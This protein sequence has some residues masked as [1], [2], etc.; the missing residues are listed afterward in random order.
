MKATPPPPSQP[1]GEAGPSQNNHAITANGDRSHMDIDTIVIDT[2]RWSRC[3][4]PL[5]QKLMLSIG[6][7]LLSEHVEVLHP[8][9]TQKKTT[10]LT[11]KLYP[12]VIVTTLLLVRTGY[13]R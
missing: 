1:D 5:P 8:S 3:K 6:I 13:R 7:P 2:F 12:Q 4:K 9:K 10:Q 11:K